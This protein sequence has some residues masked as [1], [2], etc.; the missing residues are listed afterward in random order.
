MKINIAGKGDLSSALRSYN[1]RNA[2]DFQ[3]INPNAMLKGNIS[4]KSLHSNR[5]AMNMSLYHQQVGNTTSN[6]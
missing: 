3:Y 4:D 1:P 5:K 2:M 6:Q